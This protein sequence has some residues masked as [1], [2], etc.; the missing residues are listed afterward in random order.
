VPG[1]N[2]VAADGGARRSLPLFIAMAGLPVTAAAMLL[3]RT[4]VVL[5][6]EMTW[7]LLY[8]L[9][10]AWQLLNG[11]IPHLDFHEPVGA[12]NFLVT[13]IGFEL[14]GLSPFAFVAGTLL[15][16]LAVFASA[17][18]AAIARLRL[19]P[20][21][22]FVTFACL[23]VLMPANVGDKPNAY[24]FAMSYNRY[25]WSLLSILTLIFFLPRRDSGQRYGIDLLNAA[26]VLLAMYYIKI[27][28]F[29]AALGLLAA[30]IALSPHMWSRRRGWLLLLGLLLANAAAPWNSGYLHDI[31]AAAHAGAVRNS[32]TFHLNNLFANIE[33]YAAYATLLGVALWLSARGLAPVR[34]PLA[35]AAI[36]AAGLLVLSQNQQSHGL[37]LGIV[38]AFVLYDHV[39]QRWSSSVPA[40]PMLALFVLGS[41][42]ASAYSLVSYS[43]QSARGDALQVVT[44]TQIKGLAVPAEPPGLLAAFA[45]DQ[46]TPGL[47]NA[48]RR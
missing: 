38:A 19:V 25:G 1:S 16:A 26:A 6:R 20:A 43:A 29:A 11:H 46:P 9:A 32:V 45:S 47:L 34:L 21:L 22:L 48:A 27:T 40:L 17:T 13:R 37:P 7:D 5:S 15:V 8:N 36:L 44:A 12:L 18:A 41:V 23:L 35:I 3:L 33:G 28:Y 14:A 30:A 31:L 24:S 39:H 10:G 2:E 4:D 42:G